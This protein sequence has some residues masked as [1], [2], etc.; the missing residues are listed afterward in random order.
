MKITDFK[1]GQK[2]VAKDYNGESNALI[3][4]V[5]RVD[6]DFMGGVAGGTIF[7]TNNLGNNDPMLKE[8]AYR[9]D[10][11]LFYWKPLPK[12][13]TFRQRISSGAKGT[14][15]VWLEYD[16]QDGSVISISVEHDSLP[17]RLYDCTPLPDIYASV[18]EVNHWIARGTTSTT[19]LFFD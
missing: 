4:T 8:I 5:S 11:F 2:Y 12:S 10:D 13:D 6:P 7:C 15:A 14:K 18:K 17:T 9:F 1:V 3:L 16:K 19:I